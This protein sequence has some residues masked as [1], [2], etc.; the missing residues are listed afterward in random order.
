VQEQLEKISKEKKIPITPSDVARD[1]TI[2]HGNIARKKEDNNAIFSF[3]NN[4]FT[5]KKTGTTVSA[6]K[7]ADGSLTANSLSPNIKAESPENQKIPI[8]LKSPNLSKYKGKIF[9]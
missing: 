2:C 1:K 7:R 6:P 8:G 4:S 9:P 3:L 5:R